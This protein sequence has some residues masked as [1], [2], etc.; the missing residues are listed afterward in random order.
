MVRDHAGGARVRDGM[1]VVVLVQSEELLVG[2]VINQ[3]DLLGVGG[4]SKLLLLGD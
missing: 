2:T 1:F 4:P 3:D